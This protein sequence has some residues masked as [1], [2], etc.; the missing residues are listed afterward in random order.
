VV[1]TPLGLVPTG[2]RHARVGD[3]GIRWNYTTILN[4]VFLVLAA[5]LVARFPRTGGRAMHRDDERHA[6]GLTWPV[7][8][9]G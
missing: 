8:A 4:I 1:F 2:A 7:G 9:G 3:D 6:R 5:A